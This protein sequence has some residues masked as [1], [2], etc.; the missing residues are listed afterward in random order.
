MNINDLVIF[1]EVYQKGSINQAA[2]S[3]GYAQ[4]N[5]SQRIKWLETSYDSTF[6]I[7]H[8]NGISS[9]GQGDLFYQ[10]AQTIIKETK[11]IQ[12]KLTPRKKKVLCSEILFNVLYEQK[13]LEDI[14]FTDFSIAST[15]HIN[16]EL[17]KD[18]YDQIISFN[19]LETAGYQLREA[20]NLAFN[21]FGKSKNIHDDHVPLVVNRDRLCPLRNE[22]MRVLGHQNVFELDS[23]EGMVNIVEQGDGIALL[24]INLKGHKNLVKMLEEDI[25][26]GYYIYERM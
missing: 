3:L 12:Q 15:S 16:T 6:F 1:I 17:E 23:F 22:A 7:R 10:Y 11:L 8:H 18:V 13:V 2:K 14:Q 9:T 20:K 4:S 21:L 19:Q 25:H 24:P 5:I 26:I